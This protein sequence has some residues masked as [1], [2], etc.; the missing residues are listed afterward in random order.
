MSLLNKVKIK[1]LK[2]PSFQNFKITNQYQVH[3]QFC[4][5]KISIPLSKLLD[6]QKKKM[7]QKN[8]KK[9]LHIKLV[10]MITENTFIK[11]SLQKLFF[12]KCSKR[13][14]FKT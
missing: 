1:Y 13:K 2:I 10:S 5:N 9:K 8:L 4:R 3:I 12:S 7:W 14:Y 6:Y 11:L